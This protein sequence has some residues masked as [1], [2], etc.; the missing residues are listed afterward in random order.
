MKRL[1]SLTLLL[2]LCCPAPAQKISFVINDGL[3]DDV[4]KE[5][6]DANLSLLLTEC[7]RATL[8]GETALDLSAVSLTED[9]RQGLQ[10]LWRNMPFRCEETQI[11][12]RLLQTCDGGLQVRNVPVTLQDVTGSE[13]YKELVINMDRSGCITLVNLSVGDYL[14]RKVMSAG[15]DVSDLRHRQMILDYV[16]QFR[17]AYNTKDIDFLKMV[18]SDDALIITGKVVRSKRSDRSA[19]MKNEIVYNKLSKKEYIDR[20]EY[21]VFR[22]TRYIKVNFSDIQVVKHPTL[23]GYYGVRVKQGYESMYTSGVPYSDEGY[24][25]LLWDFRD[26]QYPQIHV[27]TWQ[28]Y[29]MDEE[30]TQTIPDDQIININ[31]FKIRK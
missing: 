26:E 23:E 24:L 11:V 2:L 7:N 17:T 4:L 15:S 9:A 14:Y 31:N 6:I 10:M 25:F 3:D 22:N 21:R 28:P 19:V 16:E 8:A 13:A 29:W 18:F 5:R 27:R 1:L 30:K 12:E 20:L